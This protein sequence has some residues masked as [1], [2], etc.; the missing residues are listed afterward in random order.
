MYSKYIQ[1]RTPKPPAG[2]DFDGMRG[3]YSIETEEE[4][5]KD[6]LLHPCQNQ[7]RTV[8]AQP[9]GNRVVFPVCIF[10]AVWYPGSFQE[11]PSDR[12]QLFYKSLKQ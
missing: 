12:K 8:A 4:K 7:Q 9:S 3:R 1:N 5:R 10:A 6:K 11:I 2:R